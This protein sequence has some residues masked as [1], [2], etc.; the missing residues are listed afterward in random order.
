MRLKDKIAVVTGASQGIGRAIALR[1][2]QEGAKVAH[3]CSMCG[4]QF[5]SMKITEDVRQLAGERGVAVEQALA[6]GLAEKGAEFAARGG[7]LYTR[8]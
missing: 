2:G 6:Q 5:C 7:Q 3:F 1:L 4:P 8:P